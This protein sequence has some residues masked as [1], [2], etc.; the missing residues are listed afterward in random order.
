MLPGS[1]I[2]IRLTPSAFTTKRKVSFCPGAKRPPGS[3]AFG[4]TGGGP[5]G[6]AGAKLPV[7]FTVLALAAVAFILG[8][9]G[10]L[11]QTMA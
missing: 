2:G 7:A 6:T 3:A 8:R 1:R 9:A 4:T 10:K 5:D 11:K